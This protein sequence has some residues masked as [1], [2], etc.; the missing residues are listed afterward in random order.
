M[1]IRYCFLHFLG[2]RGGFGSGAEGQI[3]PF[4][5]CMSRSQSIKE[6]SSHLINNLNVGTR[7]ENTALRFL[8]QYFQCVNWI[9]TFY[10]L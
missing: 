5:F 1:I 9:N 10:R 8:I 4:A 2:I 3:L 6:G 7:S